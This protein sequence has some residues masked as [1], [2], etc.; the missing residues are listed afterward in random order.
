[1]DKGNMKLVVRKF[2]S[3]KVGPYIVPVRHDHIRVEAGEM[4]TTRLRIKIGQIRKN[5]DMFAIRK[6]IFD[7][8]H[9]RRIHFFALVLAERPKVDY[10]LSVKGRKALP[11]VSAK[12]SIKHKGA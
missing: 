9:C 2:D 7:I 4:K 11:A 10:R 1:M 5:G 8:W 12:E 6:Y 3:T